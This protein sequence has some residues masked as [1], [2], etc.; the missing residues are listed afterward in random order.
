MYS[1]GTRHY[2][3]VLEY[4]ISGERCGKCFAES[5]F[6]IPFFFFFGAESEIIEDEEKKE[7]G[8]ER[9]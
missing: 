7:L 5:S 2:Y 1:N 8:G 4:H 9:E 6:Y 3:V